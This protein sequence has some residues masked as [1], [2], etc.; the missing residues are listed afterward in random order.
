MKQYNVA[1]V[2]ASG[3]VGQEFLK[4]LEERNFPIAELT[5]FGSERSAGRKYTFKGKEI[6]V[7]L[8]QH[9]DDFKNI[10]IAFTSAGAGTSREFAETITKYGAV[11]IDNSSAF[12]M[13]PDVPL[14]VPE[15]NAEDALV[16]PRGI[17]ANPNCTTI[18]MVVVLKPIEALS[19]ITRIH[20]AS[21]QSASG[22]GAQA[23][24]E[25]QQQYKDIVEGNPVTIN[26]FAYQ[27]AYNV[28]P[29]IDVFTDNGYTKEE[30]K[31]FN[32]T[33]KIMHSDVKC[34]AM[35]V[36]ISSLRSHSEAVWIETEKP[37]EVKDVQDAIAAAPGLT[38]EDDPATKTYPMPLFTGGKDNVFVGRVR[39]DLANENGITLWLSGDQIKKGAALNAVQIGEYLV[40]KGL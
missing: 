11:M 12:R 13:D 16:R 3:A 28:I 30:M 26:K 8:L 29:Q 2:G 23:M 24:A 1:I 35:C 5:L 4:V 14:V 20:V 34:S 25:L 19:H 37:L 22:A 36:R 27:L 6:T 18:M 17:I 9:N 40:S 15:C 32:E 33:R 21:Y 10:D 38:L 31:M 39:K 7:K